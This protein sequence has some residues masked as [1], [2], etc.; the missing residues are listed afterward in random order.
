M[1]TGVDVGGTALHRLEEQRFGAGQVLV[2]GR[3]KPFVRQP[4]RLGQ[5]LCG[6]AVPIHEPTSAGRQRHEHHQSDADRHQLRRT[7]RRPGGLPGDDRWGRKGPDP[8]SGA[9]GTADR[10]WGGRHG[11][12]LYPSTAERATR[13][14]SDPGAAPS[15]LGNLGCSSRFQGWWFFPAPSRRGKSS[16]LTSRSCRGADGRLAD[17]PPS[18]TPT[19]CASALRASDSSCPVRRRQH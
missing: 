8:A 2:V 19:G 11:A 16:K 15:S 13:P 18:S 17:S 5:L 10:G 3:R 12:G 6:G 4:S 7:P 14:R 9:R 1:P